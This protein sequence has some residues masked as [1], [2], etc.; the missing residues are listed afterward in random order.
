M[1]KLMRN[2]DACRI[3]CPI[4]DDAQI[5]AYL[6]R[7][8][9]PNGAAYIEVP[10]TKIVR[11]RGF[12]LRP[13]HRMHHTAALFLISTDVYA[14][15]EDDHAE[16]RDQIYCYRSVQA[17]TAYLGRVETLDC[18]HKSLS[19]LIE[20]LHDALDVQACSLVY[21]GRVIAAI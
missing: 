11:Q 13:H 4:L 18:R 19:P 12:W 5:E 14:M 15:N 2:M 17:N 9:V 1:M 16:R 20:G 7:G 8:D 6:S 3:A 10:P 21:V